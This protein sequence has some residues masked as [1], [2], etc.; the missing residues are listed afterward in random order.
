MK[1]IYRILL[2]L[3]LSVSAAYAQQTGITGKVTDAQGAAIADAAVEVKQ[4][5]GS[6]FTTKTN[7]A[8]T[9]LIPSL[10]AADY[11]V[12][13]PTAAFTTVRTNASI[14]L[15]QPPHVHATLPIP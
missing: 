6:A 7:A 5:G 14:P 12:T 4:V 11:V 2:V 3:L 15:A 8:G 10:S 13:A 9:Y 1:M